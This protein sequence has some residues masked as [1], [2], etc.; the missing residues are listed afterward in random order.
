MGVSTNMAGGQQQPGYG[1]PWQ[2]SQGVNYGYD[3]GNWS[4]PNLPWGNW[5]ESPFGKFG[6][7]TDKKDQQGVA[8]GWWNT[9]LPW[10]QASQQGQQWGQEFD[11]RKLSDQWTQA[12]QQSQ[13]DWQKDMDK[14]S[15]EQDVWARGLQENQ[16]E[17]QKEQ[18]NLE[19][20]GRRFKP[21][22]RWI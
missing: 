11:W 1:M 7:P 17:A 18:A 3:W 6:V 9:I 10:F 12:F 21:S 19:A 14:W 22:T 15:K 20:F 5:G 4:F 16:L 13:F 8:Q 2:P